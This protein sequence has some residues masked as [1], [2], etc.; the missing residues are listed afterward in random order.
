MNRLCSDLAP[1][2]IGPHLGKGS[3]MEI[4][5]RKTKRGPHLGKGSNMEIT[6]RKTKRQNSYN[7]Y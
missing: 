4:T 5:M 2:Y 1:V 7:I 6:M 3:N